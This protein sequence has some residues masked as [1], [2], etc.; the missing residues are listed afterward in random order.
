MGQ[1]LLQTESKW[2]FSIKNSQIVVMWQQGATNS[3]KYGPA[4]KVSKCGHVIWGGPPPGFGV[5]K[6]DISPIL[7]DTL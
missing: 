2:W 3:C 4:A 1:F 5:L 7:R 6:P